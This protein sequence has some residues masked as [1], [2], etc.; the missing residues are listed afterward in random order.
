MNH[1]RNRIFKL[2]IAG[3]SLGIAACNTPGS[4]EVVNYN[5][6]DDFEPL[7]PA[8]IFATPEPRPETSNYSTEQLSRGRYL[9]GLLG[10]GSCHTDGALVGDPDPNRLLAGSRTGIAY[11]NP[12]Q[13]A[14][15]G[16]VY[17]ANLTPDLETGLGSWTM[18]RLVTMIRV[19]TTEHSASSLPVMPWPAY[20]S[21]TYEDAL[22]IAAYLKSLP[23]VRHDVPANVNRGQRAT[24]PYVHFGVYQSRGQR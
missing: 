21:I 5:P 23:P 18:D 11:T 16:V 3:L 1:S 24:A 20:A 9:V 17:P 6:L 8:S 10:C 19:G 15:P 13:N 12:L 4:S 14:N 2:L 7:D 22:S